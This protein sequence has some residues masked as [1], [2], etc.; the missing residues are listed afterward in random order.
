M[1]K[2]IVDGEQKS[3][4]DHKDKLTNEIDAETSELQ[5]LVSSTKAD[6]AETMD[7]LSDVNLRLQ[8]YQALDISIVRSDTLEEDFGV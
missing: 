6:L 4:N 5:E 8:D 3:L 1:A 7:R 2:E